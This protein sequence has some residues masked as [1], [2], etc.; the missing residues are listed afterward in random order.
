[1]AGLVFFTKP[2]S[3]ILGCVAPP[4]IKDVGRLDVFLNDKP[5]A[6]RGISSR[7]GSISAPSSK[8][9]LRPAGRLTSQAAAS[10]S[11]R[12]GNSI[13]MKG[14]FG[15]PRSNGLCKMFGWLIS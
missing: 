2:E 13:N 6:V 5:L 15:I 9:P 7:I 1:V 3:R 12:R 4:V 10:G 8:E 11:T 14:W